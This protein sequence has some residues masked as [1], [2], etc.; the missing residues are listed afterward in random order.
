VGVYLFA[1]CNSNPQSDIIQ[2]D[3]LYDVEDTIQGISLIK[4]GIPEMKYNPLCG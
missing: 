3:S 1:G 4:T 2:T